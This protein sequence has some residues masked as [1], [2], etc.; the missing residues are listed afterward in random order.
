M[1]LISVRGKRTSGSGRAIAVAVLAVL[2][3]S[4]P[5]AS[6]VR[7][8][9]AITQAFDEPAM[10]LLV[11]QLMA[12]IKLG[13]KPLPVWALD[14]ALLAY[15]A[16]KTYRTGEKVEEVRQHV[17]T[18]LKLV[19]EIRQNIDA[20]RDTSDRQYRRM[21]EQL[22]AHGAQLGELLTRINALEDKQQRTATQVD[23]L[24]QR[25]ARIEVRVLRRGCGYLRAQRNGRC[26]DV[27]NHTR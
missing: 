12:C 24:S 11:E 19:A 17:V 4:A 8:G 27:T 26:V 22:D 21:R 2:V 7:A 5:T 9:G 14:S 3:A 23:S 16:F 10:D 25:A 15:R 18:T 6:I 1:K 13:A 20:G